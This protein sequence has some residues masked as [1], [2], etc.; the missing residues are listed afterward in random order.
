MNSDKIPE[1][2][3]EYISSCSENIQPRLIELREVIK[4]TAPQATEKISY[5][6]PSYTL[7]GMLVYFAAHKNHIG[8]Y[9]MTSAI[10]IFQKELSGYSCS[11]GTVQF[12]HNQPLPVKLIEEIIKF[13]VEENLLKAEAKAVIKRKR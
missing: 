1:T 6:M 4:K 2:I 5:R 11:K 10:K 3:E 12:P 7:K 9:P 8:F 13:R